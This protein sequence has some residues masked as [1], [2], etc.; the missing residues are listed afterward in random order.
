MDSEA[1]HSAVSVRRS[2]VNS[3]HWGSYDFCCLELGSLGIGAPYLQW[4]NGKLKYSVVL[5]TLQGT[6]VHFNS[7]FGM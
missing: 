1:P 5:G 3:Q 7:R 2:I 6:Q 4:A